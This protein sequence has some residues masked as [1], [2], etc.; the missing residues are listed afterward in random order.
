MKTMK[1]GFTLVEIIIATAISVIILFGT[2]AILQA[3]SNQLNTIHA[4]MTLQEGPREALF[5]M[6][7]EIR[8]TAHYEITDFGG[9]NILSGN[10][11]NFRVP[12]PEPDESTLVDSSYSPLWAAD[13]RYSLDSNTQQI[14]RTSVI[15][16]EEGNPTIKQAVLANNVTA[17][18]F[19]RPTAI[20]GLV[21]IQIS[22]Q[23][24]L[25]D[26]RTIPDS[27]IVLTTQAEAR[28]P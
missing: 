26:G 20:S 24:I 7:Q 4:K 5:K 22:V 8:Q 10:E 14:L 3:S 2:F 11:I 19:S 28:N 16:D 9:G 27:P 25:S 18:T 21:T 6:A 1:C 23:L 17:L 12:V 15:L 13:I